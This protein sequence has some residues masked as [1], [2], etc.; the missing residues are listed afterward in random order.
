MIPFLKSVA[1]AYTSRYDDLSSFMFVFPNKRGGTFFNKYLLEEA[2]SSLFILPE[3]VS[4]SS[5]VET[6]SGKTEEMRIHQLFILYRCYCRIL[7]AEDRGMPSFDSFYGWGETAINDFN[8][9]DMAGVDPDEIFRN[10]SEFKDISSNFLTDS[11]REV[12]EKYFG[13]STSSGGDP[14]EFWK[15]VDHSSRLTG[16][17]LELWRILG[18]LYHEFSSE[19]EKRG[20]ATTGGLYR[21]ALRMLEDAPD[22]LLP[23]VSKIVFVG[24]NALSFTEVRIFEE[25]RNLRTFSGSDG[26]EPFADF[27]WDGTGPVLDNPAS[28]SG[29]FLRRN[30]KHFPQPA[31]ISPYIDLSDTDSLP[32]S[33]RVIS[34]PSNIA[35]TKI[36]SEE[37]EELVNRIENKEFSDANVAV[38]LPDENLLIPMLYSFPENVGNVNLTMGYSLKMTSVI[39]FVHIL[40]R[41]HLTSWGKGQEKRFYAPDLR[42]MLAHPYC[43]TVVGNS[44]CTEI[45]AYLTRY[46]KNSMSLKEIRRISVDAAEFLRPLKDDPKPHDVIEFIDRALD[47][48]QLKISYQSESVLKESLD[49]SHIDVYRRALSLLDR[50]ISDHDVDMDSRTVFALSDRMIGSEKVHF[51]GEPLSGLQ[52]MGLLETR[53]LDFDYIFILSVNE[54]VLPRRQ[55]NRSFLPNTLRT[56]YGMPPANYQES[57]FSYYFYRMISRAKEVVMIYDGRTGSYKSGEVSRYVLQL[58]YLYAREQLKREE[59]TFTITTT[60][61]DAPDVEKS[62]RIMEL[63]DLFRTPEGMPERKKISASS[64]SLYLECPMKFYLRQIV[65]IPEQEDTTGSISIMTQ[66]LIVHEV[67]E[68]CYTTPAESGKFLSSPKR[69]TKEY[70]AGLIDDVPYLM[71]LMKRAINGHHF[72]KYGS[73]LDDD[74]TKDAEIIASILIN[75]VR[76]VLRHDLTLAPF[77]LYGCEIKKETEIDVE[78]VGKVNA[79]CIIDRVDKITVDGRETFRVVD[80]KTGRAHLAAEKFDDIFAGERNSKHIFQLQFYANLMEGLLVPAGTDIRTEI[81]EVEKIG[82]QKVRLPEITRDDEAVEVVGS[83]RQIQSEFKSG[84]SEKL[85]ELFDRETPFRRCSAESGHCTFCDFRSLCRR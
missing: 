66:G 27:I 10:L 55:R 5:L 44:V 54:G 6:L 37:L 34:S 11:Q 62:D 78:G 25:L 45:A 82:R 84:V 83:H 35:Q 42:L 60:D 77:D 28:P 61:T 85:R 32:E 40:R 15:T 14:G 29:E 38:I 75:Q 74:L 21:E 43:R 65:K 63:L 50:A 46:H 19:L 67:L 7:M 33:L 76:S 23:G 39:S 22:G 26:V 52:V 1:R 58:R 72:L 57:I 49:N 80:Y 53:A 56:G 13:H 31:W 12:M 71:K 81:Y 48:V 4:I 59:R 2:R 70:L 79:V 24:F 64:L 36:A 8:E 69:I 20:V 16:K 9:V 41:L 47:A 30:R 18:P 3:I 68:R 51:E 73:A 17:F